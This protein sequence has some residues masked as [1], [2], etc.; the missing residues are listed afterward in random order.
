MDWQEP[1]TKALMMTV[2]RALMAI[3]VQIAEIY[4]LRK[5]TASD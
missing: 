4:E 1:K 5:K 3:C 2:Y